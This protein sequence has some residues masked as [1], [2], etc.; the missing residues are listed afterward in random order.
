MRSELSPATAQ[1]VSDQIAAATGWRVHIS[2]I[3]ALAGGC[4]NQAFRLDSGGEQFFLKLNAPPTRSMFEA[5]AAGL[6]EIA[7]TQTV[8]VPQP[9][10][11]GVSEDCAFIVLEYLELSRG[12][13]RS[14]RTLGQ[15]LAHM[16]R[17]TREAFGWHR[18]NTIGST[19]QDNR[20]CAHWIEFWRERRLRFQLKLAAANGY[21]GALCSRGEAL[22]AVLPKFFDGYAPRASL[23]H[24]DLWGGNAGATADGEPVIFDPAVYYGDRECDLAM[25]ELFGGFSRDFY[26][27]Y[28][29]TWPLNAGYRVRKDLYNLYHVL[30]HLNLFGGGY[31][32]QAEEMMARLLAQVR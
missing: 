17:Q 7:R 26:A 8:R 11:T 13:E 29:Q 9:I 18:N 25:T 27:A 14:A 20:E 19:P 2:R 6:E 23:L 24:G 22:L 1:H 10:C 16:H 5:E 15:N 28:A 4:I 21:G 31:L 30:N 12:T 32:A 3:E